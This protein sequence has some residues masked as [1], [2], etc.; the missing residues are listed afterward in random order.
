MEFKRKPPVRKKH[1]SELRMQEVTLFGRMVGE[2][3]AR[4]DGTYFLFEADE[5]QEPFPCVCD[6]KTAK[7]MEEYLRSGDEFTIQGELVW[8]EFR[9][10]SPRLMVYARYTDYGRKDRTLRPGA[11]LE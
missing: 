8:K 5:G 10:T 4:E 1:L 6:G 11:T 9:N 2:P 3:I 7:N